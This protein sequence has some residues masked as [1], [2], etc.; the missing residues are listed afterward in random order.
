M[1]NL[2]FIL[3]P[4]LLLTFLFS[5]CNS[6]ECDDITCLNGGICESGVCDCPDGYSGNTCATF[7]SCFNVT[8]LN[9]GTCDNGMC[10][11]PDGFGGM[12]CADTLPST[13]MTITKITVTS[14]PA[15]RSNGNAWDIADGADAY[16]SF[17]IGPNANN[18]GYSSETINDVTGSTLTFNNSLPTST[19]GAHSIDW[20]MGLWDEDGAGARELMSEITFSPVAQGA[21]N[22]ST[23]TLSNS[24]MTIELEV[25]WKY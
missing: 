2:S 10:D 21:G 8:C 19:V 17:N 23:I 18:S 25:T 6:D 4:V 20:T 24:E 15:T 12:T 13:E 22:P 1:K 5:A 3:I 11:C 14:Y 9:G 7:D 16:V